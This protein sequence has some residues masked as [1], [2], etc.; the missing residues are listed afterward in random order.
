MQWQGGAGGG[1][2][3]PYFKGM[4]EHDLPP[5]P[6]PHPVNEYRFDHYPS[7]HARELISDFTNRL[8]TLE[9]IPIRG[10]RVLQEPWQD[11]EYEEWKSMFLIYGW[12][13][14][15]DGE[16]FD[17]AVD[18]WV[19]FN[20]VRYDMEHEKRELT[21]YENWTVRG[22][23]IVPELEERNMG[24]IWDGDP[25]K[26][27]IEVQRIRMELEQSRK[28][29]ERVKREYANP[30]ECLDALKGMTYNEMME[31]SWRK[32]IKAGIK[33][34]RED[35]EWLRGDG[36]EYATEEKERELEVGIAALEERLEH[37]NELP[38]TP[39]DAMKRQEGHV[40]YLCCG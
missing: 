15:F 33:R 18:R 27:V 24:G 9:W 7:R 26:N 16:G 17:A 3:D 37:V 29:F 4:K 19:E 34:K 1:P 11:E 22:D 8:M 20:K 36:K 23:R 38:K 6:P 39:L 30:D 13:D 32:H 2:A 21:M 35:L 25:N 10:Y 5:R 12:P 40:S 14:N 31:R 28:A